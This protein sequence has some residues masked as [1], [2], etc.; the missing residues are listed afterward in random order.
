MLIEI[1]INHLVCSIKN[2]EMSVLKDFEDNLKSS[3][4]LLSERGI[5]GG[6]YLGII[7]FGLLI[8]A[9]SF[10]ANK[11]GFQWILLITTVLGII[12]GNISY[13]LFMPLFRLISQIIVLNGAN[14]TIGEKYFVKYNEVR[15]FREAFLNKNSNK[16]LKDRIQCQEKFR[17][18]L[19]Y[20]ASTN[21]TAFAFTLITNKTL[22]PSHDFI[23]LV[24][25]TIFF[26]LIST[27]V[28]ILSRAWSLGVY[29]GL[30]YN[31]ENK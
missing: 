29:I 18:T 4:S 31:E 8:T 1:T 15:N 27:F 28:G 10:D 12:I 19:T 5:L 21:I 9:S 22:N 3:Y 14:N 7:L 16:H 23:I 11:Y 6:I 17:I 24:Y 26:V 2:N 20:F 30:A 13:E 25:M